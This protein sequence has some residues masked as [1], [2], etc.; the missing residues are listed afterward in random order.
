MHELSFFEIATSCMEELFVRIEAQHS[1]FTSLLFYREHSISF[2][3]FNNL[4]RLL[5]L[6]LGAGLKFG[7]I[8][9][10]LE[11]EYLRPIFLGV[12][13]LDNI[14]DAAVLNSSVDRGLNRVRLLCSSLCQL[15]NCIP[16][17]LHRFVFDNLCA[18]LRLTSLQRQLGRFHIRFLFVDSLVCYDRD[19]AAF[20]ETRIYRFIDGI[21]YFRYL[22]LKHKLSIDHFNIFVL[23]F[24][25]V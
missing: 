5:L 3:L 4:S 15:G 20:F 18:D 16:L 10:Y 8:T 13:T 22:W 17:H 7:Q 2:F 6:F 12:V 1:A 24:G 9:L 21:D 23:K 14:H 11:I 19:Q 25:Y